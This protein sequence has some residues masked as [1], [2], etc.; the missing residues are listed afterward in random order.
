MIKVT[1]LKTADIARYLLMHF[2]Y[3]VTIYKFVLRAQLF[4]ISIGNGCEY[5]ATVVHEVMHALGFFHEQ[6]RPDRDDFVTIL[7][8]NVISGELFFTKFILLLSV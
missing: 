4:Q 2:S 1:A 5:T 8:E 7:L 3:H 6:S